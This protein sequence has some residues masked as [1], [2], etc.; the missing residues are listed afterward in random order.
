MMILANP[1][2]CTFLPEILRTMK[3]KNDKISCQ[4]VGGFIKMLE[5]LKNSEI[6]YRAHNYTSEIR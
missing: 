5:S 4:Y 2:I 1:R 3:L 6:V